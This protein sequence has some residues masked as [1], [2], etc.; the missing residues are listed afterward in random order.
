MSLNDWKILLKMDQQ[1]CLP[2]VVNK[3]QLLKLNQLH[4][5]CLQSSKQIIFKSIYFSKM[6]VSHIE[7]DL[8]LQNMHLFNLTKL[9]LSNKSSSNW[10]NFGILKKP[11]NYEI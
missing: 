4:S 3:V 10:N 9:A 7:N 11:T 2:V 1:R 5:Q 8:L 6:V